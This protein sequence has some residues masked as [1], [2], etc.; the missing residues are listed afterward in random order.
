MALKTAERY[1]VP[2]PMFDLARLRMRAV[3]INVT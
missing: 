3:S 2:T 1:T